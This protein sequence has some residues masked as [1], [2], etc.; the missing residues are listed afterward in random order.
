LEPGVVKFFDIRRVVAHKPQC[1]AS[2]RVHTDVNPQ[3]KNLTSAQLQFDNDKL[4]SVCPAE[5][6][7]VHLA[8]GYQYASSC[9]SAQP[10][11]MDYSG[12]LL[13][14]GC[15]DASLRLMN[16]NTSTSKKA[17]RKIERQPGKERKS[18]TCAPNK[19]RRDTKEI[20]CDESTIIPMVY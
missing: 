5:A 9:K 3:D 1:V 19:R 15:K 14:V 12:D 11:C 10:T 8:S 2:I 18:S 16:F 20:S 4:I 6:K 7:V 17:K 13:F